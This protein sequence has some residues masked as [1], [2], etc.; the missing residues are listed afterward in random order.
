MAIRELEHTEL[1]FPN[2]WFAVEFS[3]NL[4]VGDSKPVHVFGEDFVLFR[5]RSG[6][7]RL[8]DAYCP[9]LGAHLG[10][11]TR[12]IGEGVRCPFHGWQFD[13]ESGKCSLIPYTERI[14]NEAQVR[15]W[16]VQEKNGLIFA[17]Y[18]AE[19]K[20]PEW[21]FPQLPE[22]SDADW[23][24]ART[25]EFEMPT[26]VQNMNENNNDPVHFVYVH[27]ALETPPTELQYE[28][29]GRVYR[30]I[31]EVVKQTPDGPV[32]FKLVRDCWGLGLAAVRFEGLPGAGLLMF[33]STTPIE[34]NRT[35]SRW[36]LTAT[37]NIIDT[38]GAEFMEGIT[39]GVMHDTNIWGHMINRARP[40][41]CDAD[42]P[43]ATYR[44]W[45]RQFYSE[46]V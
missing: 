22:F 17:W 41:L 16:D 23:S 5:T 14:P 4:G 46:P 45:V 30:A 29:D 26:H 10:Y 13:G 12:V 21:D 38:A 42:A 18:H 15:S 33:S 32:P 39:Q 2:G 1:P 25:F 40:V 19:Q 43:L 6:K 7:A 3:K 28:D 34:R 44:K 20:P 9:H 8:L 37:N 24:E 11:D 36:L 31:S 35:V 27:G